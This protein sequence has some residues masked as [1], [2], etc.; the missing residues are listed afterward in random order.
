MNKTQSKTVYFIQKPVYAALGMLS[1][2]TNIASKMKTRKNLSYICSI[3]ELYAA[4]VLI[5][6][7]QSRIDYRLEIKLNNWPMASNVSFGYFAEFLDQKRTNPYSVWR[8]YNR[9]SYPNDT[10]LDEMIHAQVRIFFVLKESYSIMSSYCV[11]F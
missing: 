5:S 6:T 9:S 8:K 3:G 1:S 2:L 11:C 10:V 4:V 7:E